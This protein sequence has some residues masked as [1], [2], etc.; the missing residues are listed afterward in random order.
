MVQ[1]PRLPTEATQRCGELLKQ[2]ESGKGGNRGNQYVPKG[3]RQ[4]V[5][6]RLAAGRAAGLS[7][8][9][10]KTALRVAPERLFRPT[11]EG[12]QSRYRRAFY[13]SLKRM[14]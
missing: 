13:D 10:V 11:M 8:G 12:D 2:V 5:G 1:I 6:S 14:T 3:Q 7:P 9:Q 4:P